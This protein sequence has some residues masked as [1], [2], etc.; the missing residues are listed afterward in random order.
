MATPFA[1]P[2]VRNFSVITSQRCPQQQRI[3]Y[4]TCRR[5]RR[6][7]DLLL[8]GIERVAVRAHFDLQIVSEVEL[9]LNELP[10]VQL[11]VISLYSGWPEAFMKSH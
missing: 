10:H 8:P 7:D 5:G 1:S 11:T 4:G 6:I 3:S 9:V 2:M